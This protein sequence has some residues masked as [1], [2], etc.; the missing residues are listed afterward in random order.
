MNTKTKDMEARVQNM[1]H[2][3]KS[4]YFSAVKKNTNNPI[5]NNEANFEYND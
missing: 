3:M 4:Y 5:F 1:L 2:F